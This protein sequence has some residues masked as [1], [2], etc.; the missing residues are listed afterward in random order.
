MSMS[1]PQRLKRLLAITL[2]T[3]EEE[4]TRAPVSDVAV[5]A[6]IKAPTSYSQCNTTKWRATGGADRLLCW[7]LSRGN[8]PALRHQL[9]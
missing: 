5:D 3:E 2:V 8:L 6:S 7:S 4:N 1:A 9:R